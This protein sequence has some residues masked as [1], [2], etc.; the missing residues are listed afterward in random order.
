M[1]SGHYENLTDE[2]PHGHNK[3]WRPPIISSLS[4]TSQMLWPLTTTI[5]S[6]KSIVTLR[7]PLHL[8]ELETNINFVENLLLVVRK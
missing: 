7:I 3:I 2:V 1:A 8:P 4:V 5:D 6:L